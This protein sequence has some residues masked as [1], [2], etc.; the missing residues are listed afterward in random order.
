MTYAKPI[1]RMEEH[2]SGKYLLPERI[3]GD[4]YLFL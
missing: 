3:Q 4:F 2:S 1:D